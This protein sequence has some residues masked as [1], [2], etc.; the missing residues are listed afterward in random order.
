M[1]DETRSSSAR[2]ALPVIL[3]AAV[4]Q[5]WVLYGLHHAVK[6]HHWPATD[7]AWLVALYALAV[8]IPAT[9]QLLAEHARRAAL[10][11]LVAMLAAAYFYFGWHH[12]AS[13]S[14]AADQFSR[15]EE[16]FPL[17]LLLTVL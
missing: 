14:S 16:Y 11:W 17:A 4:V 13:V 5:G 10:W 8:F 7:Q 12:G 6:N 2:T 9:L 15:S 1:E 3:M